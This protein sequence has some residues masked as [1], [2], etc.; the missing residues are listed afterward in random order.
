M[1]EEIKKLNWEELIKKNNT[2]E[3]NWLVS[4]NYVNSNNND[5]LVTVT[6]KQH[7]EE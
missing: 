5:S 4:I 7:T 1:K 6:N 2:D 3:Q